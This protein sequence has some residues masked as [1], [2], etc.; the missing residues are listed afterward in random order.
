MSCS[1]GDPFCDG[2]N[3]NNNGGAFGIVV[4]ILL[5]PYLPFMIVGYELMDNISN[6][7]NLFKWLGTAIGLGL[8]IG[9]YFK[10]FRKFIEEMLD[11]QSSILYWLICY[12]L[13]TIVFLFLKPVFPE[14]KV[15]N[16]ISNL[17]S[18]IF[19][20]AFSIS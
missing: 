17:W 11:I 12:I 13:A 14:N 20:W 16:I 5:Y 9:F 3:C 15:I 7:V 18:E 4:L 1:C 8:G 2:Y 19:K 6:G 10:F